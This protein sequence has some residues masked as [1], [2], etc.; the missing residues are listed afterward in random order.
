MIDKVTGY[1]NENSQFKTEIGKIRITWWDA[2]ELESLNVWDHKDSLMIGA[3]L[4]YVD[5]S[6]LSLIPPGDPTLDA[7]RLEKAKLNLLTHAGDSTLNINLWIGELSDLF[8]SGDTTAA[9]TKF[10]IS[11]IEL[12]QTEF[13]LVN[14]NLEPLTEGF[15]YSRLIFKEI[16]G[17]AS[18]FRVEGSEIGI[19]IKLL[20]GIESTSGLKIQELKTNL[21]YSPDFIEL[22]QLN[23]KSDKS[24]IKNY[25]RLDLT[26]PD[27]FSD[28][29]NQVKLT[30][31]ME[32]TKI[33]L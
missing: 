9:A 5:F 22:D 23:L 12:R 2:V 16:F 21:T 10:Y 6:L 27:G 20:T 14:F 8:G 31:R 18:N 1:L 13:S 29:I 4:A 24:H 25:I 17:N 26:G 7:V 15:D 33:D 3:D 32:E 19:D 11:S 30:A 28:F